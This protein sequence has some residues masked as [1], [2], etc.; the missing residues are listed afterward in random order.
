MARCAV[1]STPVDSSVRQV[2]RVVI[3]TAAV[4]GVA[5][6][7]ARRAG[8]RRMTGRPERLARPIRV[9]PP[10]SA[11]AGRVEEE[12][13][14][15]PYTLQLIADSVAREKTVDIR[16]EGHRV[17]AVR[18]AVVRLE[19]IGTDITGDRIPDVVVQAYTGGLHC[20]SQAIVLSLGDSVA[21]LGAID[22][23]DGEIE[24]EDVDGDGFPEARIGDWR[25]AYWRDYP[26]AVTEAPTVI[27]KFRDGAFRP[28]CDL[29]R[30]DAPGERTLHQRAAELSRG[31]VA[32]D[33]PPALYGYAVELVYA[34]NA[35]AAWR[36]LDL[37]WPE[38]IPGKADFIRDLR[39]QLAGSPCW[40]PPP[41]PRP[42]A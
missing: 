9:L 33:P 31:W 37:A 25:F 15:G 2:V 21:D 13:T 34:G 18:A 26:F 36:F 28:A 7:V 8:E 27:L 5:A 1:L 22:G 12:Y 32:G 17:Y 6:F 38:R 14:V 10:D 40:S 23:A 20:C 42:A 3:A 4:L 24:F 11:I 29:M 16:R 39:E 41:E 35:D 19:H 30:E